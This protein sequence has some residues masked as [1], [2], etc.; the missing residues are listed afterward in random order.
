MNSIGK[1]SQDYLILVSYIK[2]QVDGAE[3]H[4]PQ[5]EA[6]TGVKMD[7]A[8]KSK[9]RAVIYSSGRRY[10][11]IKGKG[12]VLDAP[13]N[14]QRISDTSVKR[15]GGA[16]RRSRKTHDVLAK[17][18]PRLPYETQE[19]FR[20]RQTVLIAIDTEVERAKLTYGSKAKQ[21]P[22]K[23]EHIPLPDIDI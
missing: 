18:L 19:I 15:I 7:D 1:A 6:Q 21:L 17:H 13:Q 10:D 16:I 22:Q 20:F 12:I 23:T 14:T 2:E 3:L 8:G 5:I 4:F 11:S 9:L